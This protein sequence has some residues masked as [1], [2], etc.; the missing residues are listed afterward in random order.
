ML[1][2]DFYEVSR[3]GTLRTRAKNIR[4]LSNGAL[5]LTSIRYDSTAVRIYGDA[6]ILTAISVNSGT[7]RG[8]AFSNTIR[9]TRVFLRRDGR[10]QAVM[11]QQTP[12]Q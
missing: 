5:R 6:A 1:A 2:S 4:D 12:M 11:M 9:Y 8:T 7:F 10:W 3:L